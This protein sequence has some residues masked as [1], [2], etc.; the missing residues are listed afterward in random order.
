MKIIGIIDI[1]SNSIRLVLVRFGDRGSFKIINDLKESVRLE[2]GMEK[3]NHISAERIDKAIQTLKMFKCMCQSSGTAEIIVVGTEAL[4]RAVNRD[5][6][7]ARVEQET[8]LVV[9]VLSGQEE[10]YYDYL[11]VVNSMHISNALLMDMGGGSTEL[12]WMKD[13]RLHQSVSL[14]IGTIN[15]GQRFKL[16]GK[17][18]PEQQKALKDYLFKQ[19]QKVPW[20]K[21]VEVDCLIGI[22]GSVR[23]IAKIDRRCKGYA[24][25]ITHHYET[26]LQDIQNIYSEL[27]A[28]SLDE[29]SNVRGLS[30]ERSD[31]IVGGVANVF[32]LMEYC[33]LNQLVVSGNGLRE[34]LI[35]NNMQESGI[36][37][38]DPL[39]YSIYNHLDSFNLSRDHAEHVYQLSRTLFEQLRDIHGIEPA[40]ENCLKT[41]A[42]L[43]HSGLTVNYNN[44]H[45]HSLYMIL[46]SGLGG[47]THRDLLISALIAAAH[48]KD[49]Y[50]VDVRLYRHLLDKSDVDVIHKLG[51]LV[52]IAEGLDRSL[53]GRIKEIQ[54]TVHGDAVIIK[55][56]SRV[57]V[58]LEINEANKSAP[59]FKRVFH[60]DLIIV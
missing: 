12:V 58:S 28:M 53:S 33:S 47:I 3:S 51:L 21:Q 52:R 45:E 11:G 37:I 13:G 8:G 30:R 7:L 15:L 27:A 9:K 4:R 5:V 42:M 18:A 34:G 55:T 56:I 35:F 48:N 10:A 1:G 25:E 60:K 50:K 16:S 43:H 39:H 54:C 20:L 41:G 40:W 29:R 31:L 24:L 49:N 59:Y 38:P 23:N 2:E 19:Y 57:D 44:Y 14:P 6:M 22:G 26:S 32:Y 46:N 17:V 36:E